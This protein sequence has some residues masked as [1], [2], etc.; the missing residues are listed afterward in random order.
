MKST[1]KVDCTDDSVELEFSFSTHWKHG[2]QLSCHFK[3]VIFVEK[4]YISVNSCIEFM[5]HSNLLINL[6]WLMK[7]VRNEDTQT[8]LKRMRNLCMAL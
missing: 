4:N 5:K 7:M 6:W 3:F 2:D 1:E 8:W